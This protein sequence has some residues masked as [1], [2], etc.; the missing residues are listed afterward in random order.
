V[1]EVLFQ[2]S[3]HQLSEEALFGC[4]VFNNDSGIEVAADEIRNNIVVPFPVHARHDRG[5]AGRQAELFQI[6]TP[7]FDM[8]WHGIDDYAV[9]VEEKREMVHVPRIL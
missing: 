4:A 6:R 2:S 9:E 1:D 8:E 3:V 5:F 7:G